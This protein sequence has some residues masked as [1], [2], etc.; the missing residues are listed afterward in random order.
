MITIKTNQ[1]FKLFQQLFSGCLCQSWRHCRRKTPVE[2]LV[3]L[4]YQF[5]VTSWYCGNKESVEMHYKYFSKKILW[6]NISFTNWDQEEEI[7]VHVHHSHTS[8]YSLRLRLTAH[9][10]RWHKISFLKTS[11][12]VYFSGNSANSSCDQQSVLPQKWEGVVA[13]T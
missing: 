9:C 4:L 8:Q 10:R 2:F 13:S 7:E 12:H 6:F 5:S 3:S 1:I 11:T